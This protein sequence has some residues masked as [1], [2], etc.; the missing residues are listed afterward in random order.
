[1]KIPVYASRTRSQSGEGGFTLIELLIALLILTVG[2]FGLLQSVNI[3]Y[4]H[5]LRRK[6]RD[7]AAAI[8]E[9][10]LNVMRHNPLKPDPLRPGAVLAPFTTANRPIGGVAKEFTVSRE[11][12][13]IGGTS[14]KL[15]V[16]VRWSFKNITAVHEIYTIRKM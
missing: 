13:E 6:L 8:A 4:E 12:D 1:M 3:A 7:E 5:N 16:E 2:L 9:E 15:K 11:S 14:R 10:Q